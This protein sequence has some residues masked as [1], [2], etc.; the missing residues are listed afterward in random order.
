VAQLK[1]WNNQLKDKYSETSQT[2]SD[3]R[4]KHDDISKRL[5]AAESEAKESRQTASSALIEI[6]TKE[7]EKKLLENLCADTKAQLATL[8]QDN[9]R[10]KSELASVK[11]E[12]ERLKSSLDTYRGRLAQFSES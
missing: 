7:A 10:L 6:K 2:L 3:L 8:V 11:V 1:N 5:L 12:A 4:Q 9:D